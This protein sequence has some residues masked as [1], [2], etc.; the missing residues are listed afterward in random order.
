MARNIKDNFVD[1]LLQIAIF[2]SL[3][4]TNLRQI[5]TSPAI[6]DQF[7]SGVSNWGQLEV[8]P[9]INTYNNDRWN[10]ML[11]VSV[12][13]KHVENDRVEE[14]LRRVH[15]LAGYRTFERLSTRI[16]AFLLE[17]GGDASIS[18]GRGGLRVDAVTN[19][20]STLNIIGEE[21]SKDVNIFCKSIKYIIFQTFLEFNFKFNLLIFFYIFCITIITHPPTNH[22]S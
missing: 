15:S 13:P 14:V 21:P 1:G 5:N 18:A 6:S 3:I 19:Q 16:E 10:P 20:A 11:G 2:L 17:E 7:D 9:I 4:K 8:S 12:H 22:F